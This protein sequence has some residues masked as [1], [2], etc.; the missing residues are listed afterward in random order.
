MF[1]AQEDLPDIVAP[2]PYES[3]LVL[4]GNTNQGERS[5]CGPDHYINETDRSVLILHTSGTTGLPKPIYTSHKHV[6]CFT[7]CHD[8]KNEEEVHGLNV[9]TLPLYHVSSA[10]FLQIPQLTCRQGFGLVAPCLSMGAGKAFCLPPPNVPPTGTSVVELLYST[11]AR[12]LMSVPSILEEIVLMAGGKGIQALSALQFVAFGGGL[13]KSSVGEGLSAAGVKLL[14]HYGTTESGPLAPIFVPKDDYDWRY[15]RLRKDMNLTL[16]PVSTLKDGVQTYKLTTRPFGWETTFE[17]QDQLV[18]NPRLPLTDFNAVGR[19]DDL[20]VL[21]TG[22]KVLPQILE[23]MLSESELVKAAV[24]FGSGHLELGI[25]VE[26]I[27]F[28]PTTQSEELKARLWPI[29]I[30][31]NKRMDGHAEIISKDAMII[32]PPRMTI[33]RTDKGSIARKEAYK[34]FEG[35]IAKAYRDLE[36]NMV[37]DSLPPFI[38]ATIEESLSVTIQNL[39]NWRIPAEQWGYDDD[40]F[41]L[42]MNS[43]QSV[44]LRRALLISLSNSDGLP[45]AQWISRDFVYQ[46]P[47]ITSMAAALRS[48]AAPDGVATDQQ[49]R[50]NDFVELFSVKH[51][52]PRQGPRG[53]AVVL[54][55]GSTGSLGCHL[56]A[57][58]IILPTVAGVICLN[59]PIQG[60][61][62]Q[63]DLKAHV[64]QSAEAKGVVI[65]QANWSRIEV[66]GTNT[67]APLLGLQISEYTDL[68]QRVTHI[69]HNAWPMDFK[70]QL[71][72]FQG[73]FQAIENLLNLA[74]DAHT[75]RPMVKPRFLFVSS[76]AVV[77]LFSQNHGKRIIPEVAMMDEKSTN[78]TGYSE[79]KLVCEK[80]IEKAVQDYGDE[81]EATYVRVGQM[82]GSSKSGF[83][84]T[85]EHI[86]GLIKSSQIVGK[87]PLLEGVCCT[88]IL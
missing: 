63:S 31:A 23:S 32:V 41:D 37:D 12:S 19:D 40:F 27:S 15:F 1:T 46:H 6:L 9:S 14:N 71:L 24:A 50:T 30:E 65:S 61:S 54:L 51:G 60:S 52:S 77:G 83:W 35:E 74:R 72:S 88:S 78:P 73:Q 66:F 5:V 21:A 86:A 79:A 44:Q 33:P 29:V 4:S 58:L 82:S 10:S 69:L 22:E 11:N 57:H 64:Q 25:I 45:H 49:L 34:L 84:N 2:I 62:L 8:F 17:I 59:R 42:G 36:D 13:L 20:I 56:L 76:I 43:L 80:I 75:T 28:T 3:F 70:R 39:V 85:S 55:T 53:G 7:V 48:L 67:A 47:S 38:M 26:P 87:L 81:M 18:A 68:C 16:D